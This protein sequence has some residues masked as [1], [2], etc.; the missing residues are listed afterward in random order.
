MTEL[1][2]RGTPRKRY[3]PDRRAGINAPIADRILLHVIKDAGGC[4]IWTAARDDHGY[5]RI[6]VHGKSGLY[7]HRVSYETFVGPVPEGLELDHLCRVRSCCNPAHLEPVTPQVN[8]LRGMAPGAR[9][10]R[11]D[12]CKFGV[13]AYAEHGVLYA[14]RRVCRA[15]QAAYHSLWSRMTPE[16][17]DERKRAGLPVVDLAAHYAGEVGRVA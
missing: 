14:G 2:K 1:T 16:E 15:C 5:G 3:Y 4:W 6:T 13:H 11:R 8:N 10:R 12:L 9:A 7:C 17:R